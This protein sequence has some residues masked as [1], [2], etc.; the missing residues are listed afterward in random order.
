MGEIVLGFSVVVVIFED[1]E[2]VEVVPYYCGILGYN[3][4]SSTWYTPDKYTPTLSAIQY[5]MRVTV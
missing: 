5:C 1:W 2:T 4:N 3:Q